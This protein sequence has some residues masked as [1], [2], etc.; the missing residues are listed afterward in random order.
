MRGPIMTPSSMA[1]FKSEHRAAQ[2]AHRCETPHQS[3][4]S[5][6]RGQQ[7]EV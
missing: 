1:R 4:F 2:V 3:R 5:L 6:P 7:M